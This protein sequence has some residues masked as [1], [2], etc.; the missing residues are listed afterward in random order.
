M[1]LKIFKNKVKTFGM[2][3]KQYYYAWNLLYYS[4]YMN[5]SLM[6]KR[7]CMGIWNIDWSFTKIY[8]NY[9][10][11]TTKPN[12]DKKWI[13]TQVHTSIC[14]SLLPLQFVIELMPDYK[15]YAKQNLISLH[16]LK[17]VCTTYISQILITN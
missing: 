6:Q 2:L 3:S 8:K 9:F 17:W 10:D 15:A 4:K 7:N 16:S 11:F 1:R 12:I 5:D 13:Y 14:R